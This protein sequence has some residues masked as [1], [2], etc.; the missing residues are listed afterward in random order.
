MSRSPVSTYSTPQAGHRLPVCGRCGAAWLFVLRSRARGA[1]IP[2]DRHVAS[3]IATICR[4]LDG[5]PLAIKLAAAR[6]GWERV[7][8]ERD[9][10]RNIQVM[11]MKREF[12]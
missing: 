7:G 8:L 10:D 2:E 3:F 1:H 6:G 4:R 5:I 11:L 9:T 12:R